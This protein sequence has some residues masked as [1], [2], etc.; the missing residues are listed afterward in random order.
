M[1]KFYIF[2]GEQAGA[3]WYLHLFQGVASW[4]AQTGVATSHVA[5][6]AAQGRCRNRLPVAIAQGGVGKGLV[7]SI[8]GSSNL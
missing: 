3:G 1:E 7:G 5:S 4:A 8:S 2:E 6:W